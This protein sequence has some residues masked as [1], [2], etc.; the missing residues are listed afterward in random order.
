[1]DIP[2]AALVPAVLA[3]LAWIVFCL[4]DL[5]RSEVAHLPK[6]AWG[7]IIVA[8]VPLGGVLFLLLGRA[9]R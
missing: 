4:V 5:A 1:M 6:W 7:L 3:A 8:S 2:I 9:S